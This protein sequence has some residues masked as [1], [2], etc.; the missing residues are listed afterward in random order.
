MRLGL[1]ARIPWCYFVPRQEEPLHFRWKYVCN[2]HVENRAICVAACVGDMP[3][4]IGKIAISVDI[5]V[6][7]DMGADL[8][9]H[10]IVM[11]NY[12]RC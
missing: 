5:E 7:V 11:G 1:F 8:K 3:R 9:S 4:K 12:R 6:F 2:R 10:A